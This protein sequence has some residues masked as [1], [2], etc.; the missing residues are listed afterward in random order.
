MNLVTLTSCLIRFVPKLKTK[1]FLVFQTYNPLNDL[2]E[3]QAEYTVCNSSLS[4]YAVLGFELGM[5]LYW[6]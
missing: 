5:F 6:I 4:E 3:G 1:N 2:Q